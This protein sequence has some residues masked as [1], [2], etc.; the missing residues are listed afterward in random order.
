MCV[1]VCVRQ[2]VRM[3][4]RFGGIACN[5]SKPPVS[6]FSIFHLSSP[7]W[8]WHPFFNHIF[9]YRIMI[10][11]LLLF[12]QSYLCVIFWVRFGLQ[13]CG[14]L[15][16]LTRKKDIIFYRYVYIYTHTCIKLSKWGFKTGLEPFALIMV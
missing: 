12:R 16:M 6:L 10:L 8:T 7:D 2:Q 14:S 9:F 11:L 15:T 3:V 13:S 4:N 5:G 1:F